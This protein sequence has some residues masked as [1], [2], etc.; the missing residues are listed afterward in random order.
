MK[1]I[2]SVLLVLCVPGLTLTSLWSKTAVELLGWGFILNV[3]L[4]TITTRLSIALW[5]KATP[6]SILAGAGGLLV[7]SAPFVLRRPAGGVR[8]RKK[9]LAIPPLVALFGWLYSGRNLPDETNYL[10]DTFF[11]EAGGMTLSPPERDIVVKSSMGVRRLSERLYAIESEECR[12]TINNPSTR[13][14]AYQ[15]VTLLQNRSPEEQVVS[16]LLNSREL[17][18]VVIGRKYDRLIHPRNYARDKAL[19]GVKLRL[20]EGVN[21]LRL[22]PISPERT[23]VRPEGLYLYQLSGLSER[24]LY[25]LI[26]QDFIITD[27]GDLKET[28][29]FSR[30]FFTHYI[31]YS[32]SFSGDGRSPGGYTSLSDEP[33]VHHLLCS[34]ALLL[35]GDDTRSLSWLYLGVVCLLCLLT[36]DI[37]RNWVAAFC[38]SALYIMIVRMGAEALAPDTLWTLQC[39]VMLGAILGRNYALFIF[40]SALAYLTHIPALGSAYI[41][42]LC[43][44]LIFRDRE[45][46]RVGLWTTLAFASATLLLLLPLVLL[47]GWQSAL[48]TGQATLPIIGRTELIRSII[49]YGRFENLTYFISNFFQFG[50]M[51]LLGS[52][53][54]LTCAVFPKQKEKRYILLFAGVYFLSMMLLTYQ[55]SHHIGPIV[56]AL[57]S[58]VTLGGAKRFVYPLCVLLSALIISSSSQDYTGKFSS[59]GLDILS[60]PTTRMDYYAY[61]A[62]KA[63]WSGDIQLISHYLR[64]RIKFLYLRSRT[65]ES[66]WKEFFLNRAREARNL[67]RL[68]RKRGEERRAEWMRRRAEWAESLAQKPA[69]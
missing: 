65:R 41:L 57:A 33:P 47:Q 21:E 42:L 4:H 45:Y 7:L 58:G 52:G 2:S 46:V 14:R 17:L 27:I 60:A 53:L 43:G 1:V 8:I 68:Y 9:S 59:L 56:F 13:T 16:F 11:W 38:V 30:N 66:Y 29:D 67:A 50:G 69:R 18:T 39:L 61:S 5:G 23:P 49:F 31:Q 62:R 10:N 48:Y 32:T 54:I 40:M 6:L 55:R 22:V 63:F 51:I 12:F 44:L 35:T 25:Q 19:V 64:K 15:F 24:E 26:K 20:R 36:I 28:L 37:G 34:F 3:S